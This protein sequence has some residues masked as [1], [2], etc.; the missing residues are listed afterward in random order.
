MDRRTKSRVKEAKR[1]ARSEL[2][3]K[4]AW[5]M[6]N[7]ANSFH[8]HPEDIE[9]RDVLERIDIN[10]VSEKEF[11]DVYEKNYR[12]VVIRNAQT[13]WVAND[14]W[15]VERLEKKYRNQSF[16]CGEDDKGNSVRLKMKYFVTYMKHNSDDSPLYIFDSNFGE[17]PKRNK[18]LLDYSIPKYFRDDLFQY[19][20]ERKRPP[21]RWFVMGP[22]RSG[23]GIHIDPLGTSAWNALVK[24]HKW[25]C[26]FPTSCP[27]HLLK[28]RPGEGWK[29][30]DEAITWFSYVYP[31]VQDP[32]WPKEFKPIEIL[33]RPGETVFVP[34]GWWHVVLN[35]DN[36]IAVTQNFCSVTN[37]PVVWHKTVRGRPKLSKLWYNRLKMHKPEVI[38]IADSVD[39]KK[40]TMLTSDSSSCSSSSSSDY[41]CSSCDSSSDSSASPPPKRIKREI[42]GSPGR[43]EKKSSMKSAAGSCSLSP[44]QCNASSN[45]CRCN[46]PRHC[47]R[48]CSCSCSAQSRDNSASNTP[49]KCR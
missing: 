6:M 49:K 38:G 24:G 32:S 31:R 8:V 43:N 12:P 16:K 18:L 17:H 26:L 20:T 40:P 41:S 48:S 2:H 3:E 7:C 30:Q 25:W 45:S 10:Q 34:G 5:R 22:A 1:R 35:L 42:S 4:H 19:A 36:T 46:S 11:I 47:R 28:L 37:F 14:K 21:Y 33:Q 9:S 29:N 39:L 23:T 13:T 44:C 15:T 27:K